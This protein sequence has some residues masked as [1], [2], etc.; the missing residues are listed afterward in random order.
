MKYI[1]SIAMALLLVGCAT[2]GKYDSKVKTWVGKN[3]TELLDSWGAPDATTEVNGGGRMYTFKR[4]SLFLNN[5]VYCETSFRTDES[6]EIQSYHWQ[7]NGCK[8]H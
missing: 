7:G 8:S 6:G 1:P 5:P 4:Q 2:S 3:V